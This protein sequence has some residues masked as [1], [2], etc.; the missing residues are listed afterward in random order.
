MDK[1]IY[2]KR[3]KLRYISNIKYIVIPEQ[4]EKR[5]KRKKEIATNNETIKKEKLIN[6]NKKLKR[7]SEF[8]FKKNVNKGHFNFKEGHLN[9]SVDIR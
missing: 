7:L 4:K 2:R 1:K 9:L 3:L 6:Q 8:K 5:K